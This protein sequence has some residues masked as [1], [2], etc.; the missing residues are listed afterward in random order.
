MTECKGSCVCSCSGGTASASPAVETGEAGRVSHFLVPKMDCAA[1][2]RMIRLALEPLAEVAAL[3]FDL[4]GRRLQV[5]HDGEIAPIAARLES[6]GLGARL[7]SSEAVHGAALEQQQRRD[8]EQSSRQA[9]V[10]K[11]L[12][13]INALMFVVELG[14]GWLAQSTGLIADSLDMFADAAVYGVALFAVGRA[15]AWQVRAAHFAGVLQLI[16]ALGALVEVGRRFFYGSEPQSLSM[17]GIGLLALVANVA[18]LWLI[19]GH[20]DGGAHMRASWIFPANDVLAN[21]GGIVAGA[22]VAW[23]GSPYPDLLI[24]SVVGLLV[25]DGARRILALKG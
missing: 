17:I 11:W 16:L 12:L 20:R 18:C 21:L 1:E 9:G 10:L 15:L 24:G 5:F 13:A 8:A 14:S 2:E 25:L 22:L 7:E 4:P 23:T 3:A 6:L 19:S